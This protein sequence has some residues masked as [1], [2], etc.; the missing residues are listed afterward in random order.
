[1]QFEAILFPQGGKDVIGFSES[2][3][4]PESK[5]T[6]LNCWSFVKKPKNALWWNEIY[7]RL[8][9]FIARAVFASGNGIQTRQNVLV[10]S[11]IVPVI[12]VTIWWVVSVA[13]LALVSIMISALWI[14]L[15]LTSARP[16]LQNTKSL[17]R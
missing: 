1:M 5:G 12:V 6:L 10:P 14:R 7:P 13:W 16:R 9:P 4:G 15:K 11:D 17:W 8:T 3:I 2:S